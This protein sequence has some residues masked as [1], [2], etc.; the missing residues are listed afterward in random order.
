[1]KLPLTKMAAVAGGGRH[2]RAGGAPDKDGL[3]RCGRMGRA[4]LIMTD[5]E[6]PGQRSGGE[7][8]GVAALDVGEVRVKVRQR[9]G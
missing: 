6:Y 1:V 7:T 8:S 3:R 2:A 9:E 5:A 4:P